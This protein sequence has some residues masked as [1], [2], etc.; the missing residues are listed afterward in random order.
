MKTLEER[1]AIINALIV[2]HQ[3]SDWQVVSQTD[4]NVK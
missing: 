1:K 4:T 2:K 3:K